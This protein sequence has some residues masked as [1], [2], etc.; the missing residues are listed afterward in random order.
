MS[1]KLKLKKL[2]VASFVTDVKKPQLKNVKGGTGSL[3]MGTCEATGCFTDEVCCTIMFKC[4][5]ITG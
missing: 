2:T 5:A 1:K 4:S 3:V